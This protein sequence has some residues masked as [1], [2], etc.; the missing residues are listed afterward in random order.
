MS[1]IIRK[2]TPTLPQP[3]KLKNVAAYARVSLEK[4]TML[5]SFSAQVSYYSGMIQKNPGWHY[6]GVYADK[7]LTGTK[8]TRP[9]FQRLLADCR[10]G[11]ID[12]VITKSISRFARNTLTLLETV[13]ELRALGIDVFFQEQNIH[14]I[15]GDG[16]LMLSILA[17]Y[18]QEESLSV[19][20]NCKWQIRNRF[21]KGELVSLRFMY[22]Y[23]ITRGHIAI[24]PVQADIVRRV[25]R[26]YLDGIG[27]T[28]IAAQLREEQ[29]PGLR[30]GIWSP[31]RVLDMLKNEKYAGNALL[32]KKYVADHL[33]KARKL[34]HGQL[35]KY[36]AEGTHPAI[37]APE[38]FEQARA[39]MERNRI[40]NGIAC[41][42]P[43]YSAFTGKIVCDKCGKH[44]R[45]KV[46]RSEVA[47]NCSTYL[48]YGK[49]QCHTKQIPEDTLMEVT[50]SV[51]G[52]REFD[53]TLFFEQIDMIRVPAFN[54]LLFVLKDGFVVERVWQDKSRRD[55]W[56]EAM[57]QQA[58]ANA[59]RRYAK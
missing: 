11:K 36:Y 27:I 20:E 57:R 31:K 37:I 6:A 39:K 49:A 9:E 33:T 17:S 3:P 12:M 55:S 58:A 24:D 22:G 52:L 51:L 38:V 29:I 25:F 56:D 59:R 18:A 21:Q 46:S 4:E 14:S 32:Q 10:V 26:E 50:A 34:N 2:I 54:H 19:S 41:D 28:E 42:A 15:S 5:H 40:A 8:A 23:R 44:Y 53:E 47:W 45:R 48:V 7:A 35:P 43:Q 1:R 30:G 16:E 13:R